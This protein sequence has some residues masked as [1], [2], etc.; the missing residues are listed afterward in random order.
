[1]KTLIAMSGGVDSSV[2]AKCIVDGKDTAMGA[3]MR[4]Y[5]AKTADPGGRTR[6]TLEDAEDAR[7]VARRLGIPFYVFNFQDAFTEKVIV[8]FVQSY[9]C[10]RTP[11]PCIDCNRY[12]KFD[13]LLH[14]ARELG[15][16]RLATGHYARIERDGSGRSRRGRPRRCMTAMRCWAAVGSCRRRRQNREADNE[17]LNQ[18]AV[19]P[20]RDDRSGRAWRRELYSA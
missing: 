2:A 1:M 5:E 6:C 3:M 7:A 11:N 12:L 15:C 9:L 4:L 16:D 14:R 13:R 19:C 20:A 17:N 8:P 18:R 10:G